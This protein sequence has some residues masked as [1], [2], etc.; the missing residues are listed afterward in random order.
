VQFAALV[1]L[2]LA[3]NMIEELPEFFGYMPTL[4]VLNIS[5]NKVGFPLA[6][7]LAGIRFRSLATRTEHWIVDR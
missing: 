5:Y 2:S 7:A 1:D 3:H 6:C 4:K